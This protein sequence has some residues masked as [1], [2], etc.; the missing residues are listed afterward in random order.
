MPD[1]ITINIEHLKI[2][3]FIYIKDV[4][5]EGVEFLAPLNS[6]VVGVKTARAAIEEVEEEEGEEG[7]VYEFYWLGDD[8]NSINDLIKIGESYEEKKNCTLKQNNDCFHYES[9]RQPHTIFF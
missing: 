9:F 3:M 2:G 7:E 6:V 4:E 5:I 8:I 1:A